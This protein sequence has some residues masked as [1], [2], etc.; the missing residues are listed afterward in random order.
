MDLF[1]FIVWR[2]NSDYG[3]YAVEVSDPPQRPVLGSEYNVTYPALVHDLTSLAGLQIVAFQISPRI[4]VRCVEQGRGHRIVREGCDIV[5]GSSRDLADRPD[6]SILQRYGCEMR[7]LSRI[8]DAGIQDSR[9]AVEYGPRDR[10]EYLV[11]DRT[12]RGYRRRTDGIQIHVLPCVFERDPRL[13]FLI[14]GTAIDLFKLRGV[15]CFAAV[16]PSDPLHEFCRSVGV[17][18]VRHESRA[19]EICVGAD[20][21][22]DLCSLRFESDRVVKE[23][24][25]ADHRAEDHFIVG[26]ERASQPSGH[27]CFDEYCESFAI[28]SRVIGAWS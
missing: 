12:Y 24:G 22:I 17:H 4:V 26:P 19:V 10:S 21:E 18:K 13:P 7:D 5:E 3:C 2:G 1:P 8:I 9:R 20:L 6:V 16:D 25:I 14:H 11:G 23:R 28:P 27:P 15:V